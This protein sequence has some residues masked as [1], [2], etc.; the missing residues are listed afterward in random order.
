MSPLQQLISLS[1]DFYPNAAKDF[2][3]NIKNTTGYD[4]VIV[5]FGAQGKHYIA[6]KPDQIKSI[7]SKKFTEGEG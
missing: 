6:F 5:D 3:Q 2:L 4:G 1:N 7:Y